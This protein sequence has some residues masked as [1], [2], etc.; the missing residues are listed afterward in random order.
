MEEPRKLTVDARHMKGDYLKSLGEFQQF[1]REE[2]A[3]ANIDCIGMDTSVSFDRALMEYLLQ[4]QR[5]LKS[6]PFLP[7]D[8]QLPRRREVPERDMRQV[9]R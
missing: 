4:R 6:M 2:C 9:G 8:A 3:K 5:R 7:W 1:W